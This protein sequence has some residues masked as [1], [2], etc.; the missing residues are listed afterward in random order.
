MEPKMMRDQVLMRLKARTAIALLPLLYAGVAAANGRPFVCAEL[1]NA[2]AEGLLAYLQRDR[3]SLK[4]ECAFYAMEQV[5]LKH[6]QPAV[7]TLIAYLDYPV[8]AD[9]AEA[10][11]PPIGRPRM[12]GYTYPASTALL[13]IGQ[14]AVPDLIEAIGDPKTA[15]VIW[16]NAI[17]TLHDVCS[18]DVP[19]AV[20]RLYRASK[21]SGNSDVSYRLRQA[22]WR[23]AD[24]CY[25]DI[26][27]ACR[28]A[29]R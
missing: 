7:R 8:P 27:N 5:G 16:R 3:P 18:E 15:E 23:M 19:G 6:Y 25:G 21:A 2:K 14:A 22:A 13:D 4:P 29:L 26:A 12:L 1:E 28:E 9:P 24:L 11:L 17:Q 10:N 20:S